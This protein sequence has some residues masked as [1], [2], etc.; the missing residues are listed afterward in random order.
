MQINDA[1]TVLTTIS[2][3]YADQCDGD[4]EHNF[5]VELTTV[6]NPGWQLVADLHGT[7]L[8]T[9]TLDPIEEDDTDELGTNVWYYRKKQD[10]KYL[11]CGDPSQLSRMLTDLAEW[12]LTSPR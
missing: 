6:D 4:W 12:L 7:R 2:K 3:W 11:A 8:A 10:C 9:A 1:N 5:G